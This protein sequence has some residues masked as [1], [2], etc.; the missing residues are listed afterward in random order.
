[1]EMFLEMENALNKDYFY[2]QYNPTELF[3]YHY[4]DQKKGKANGEEN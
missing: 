1:M 4:K 3:Q 2:P